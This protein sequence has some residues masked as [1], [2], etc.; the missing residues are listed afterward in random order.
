MNSNFTH[1]TYP[2]VLE[3]PLALEPREGTFNGLPLLVEGLPFGRCHVSRVLGF[4]SLVPLVDV[5][6]GARVVL[7]LDMLKQGLAFD[8]VLLLG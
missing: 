7:S 5:N 1:P 2:N 4:Q 8:P 6:D 3:R